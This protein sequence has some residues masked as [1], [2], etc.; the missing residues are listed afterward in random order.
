MR[1]PLSNLNGWGT[2]DIVSHA[3]GIPFYQLKEM[4]ASVERCHKLFN[5]KEPMYDTLYFL[6]IM[7]YGDLLRKYKCGSG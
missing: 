5:K 1:N 6:K 2:D 7:Q 3:R 4:E